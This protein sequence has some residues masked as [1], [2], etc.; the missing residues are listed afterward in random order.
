[1]KGLHYKCKGVGF[2]VKGDVLFSPPSSLSCSH[3]FFPRVLELLGQE[4]VSL[5]MTISDEY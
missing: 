4:S 5:N 3:P 2:T 1:V